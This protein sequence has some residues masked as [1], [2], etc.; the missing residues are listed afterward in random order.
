MRNYAIFFICFR[1]VACAQ[2]V[3]VG[4]RGGAPLIG[5]F[6]DITV[7][8]SAQTSSGSKG[9]VVGPMIEVRLPLNVSVEGDA[10]YHPLNLVQTI[11]TGTNTFHNPITFQSWEFPILAKY[12][13]PRLPAAKPYVEG[14]PSFRAVSA[15]IDP[16]FSKA[17]ITLG[18]GLEFKLSRFRVEPEFRY[19]RWGGDSTVTGQTGSG[20][21]VTPNPA[22]SNVNQVQ[23]LVGFAFGKRF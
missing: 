16:Y 12:R 13:L 9:Y 6:S 22:P 8:P 3:L 17:G 10:L 11:N 15:A 20:P 2:T 18:A 23:F 19:T 4:V 7:P 14:G 5:P 1:A 21:V